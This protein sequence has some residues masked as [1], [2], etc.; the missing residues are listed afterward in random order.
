MR[1]GSPRINSSPA[2]QQ[3][4]GLNRDVTTDPKKSEG[5]KLRERR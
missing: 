2:R 4:L 3:R 1:F 5:E